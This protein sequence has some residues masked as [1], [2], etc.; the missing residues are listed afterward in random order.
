MISQIYAAQNIVTALHQNAEQLSEHGVPSILVAAGLVGDTYRANEAM[1]RDLGGAFHK[2]HD[3]RNFVLTAKDS[4]THNYVY[5]E[6][7][8][9]LFGVCALCK[10]D[11]HDL[12]DVKKNLML[13]AV[14]G[15]RPTLCAMADQVCR[16][17]DSADNVMAQRT[18]LA[19][20]ALRTLAVEA[21]SV[22][23]MTLIEAALFSA[24]TRP[25]HE[26]NAKAAMLNALEAHKL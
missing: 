18:K 13:I 1:E 23:P 12:S 19:N 21:K 16:G 14:A 22:N 20:D 8:Q 4:F 17:S 2:G 10:K 26:R 7:Q 25:V 11:D 6:V 3:S 9:A 15:V 5:Q 24:T